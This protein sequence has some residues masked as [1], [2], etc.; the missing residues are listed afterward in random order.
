MHQNA[1]RHIGKKLKGDKNFKNTFNTCLSGCTSEE[2][3]EQ[4]WSS[5]IKDYGLEGKAWFTRLYELRHK[6]CTA[7]NKEYFSAGILSSQRSESTNHAIGFHATK[8]TNLTEFYEIFKR[9]VQ[10]W[11]ATEQSDEFECTRAIPASRIPLTGML[12][13]ASE[14]YTL[15]LFKDFEDE[16]LKCISTTVRVL[17]EE[18]DVKIY[19]VQNHEGNTSHI[20]HYLAGSNFVNCTCKKFEES[21]ILCCHCLRILDRHSL[22]QIPEC[23]IM[24][25]WTRFAK[26]ELWNRI[27]SSTG[28][29]DEI[30]HGNTW[31]HHM[32][33]KYYNLVL[34]AQQNEEAR[35]LVQ[36]TY[37]NLS[38]T[39]EALSI[40]GHLEED[41]NVTMSVV[42]VSNPTRAVTK[43]RQKRIKGQIEKGK[44]KKK[45]GSTA[46]GK[47]NEFGTKTPNQRLF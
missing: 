40:T 28:Q 44:R 17:G 10:R 42:S 26:M 19:D 32:G 5:M 13:H 18:L 43:G 20:V 2:E 23:Y 41:N 6:W 11:R 30:P 37:D 33:R 36:D 8:S 4:C 16:L 21:G 3:F 12:K 1:V 27:Q 24:R 25:R 38:T 47:S 22:T 14:V 39:I 15:S 9:T 7:F 31:R 29:F 34:K 35:K 46:L 45:V